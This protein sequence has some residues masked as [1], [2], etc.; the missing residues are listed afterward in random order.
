M[1]NDGYRSQFLKA[2]SQYF[3]SFLQ[4][5]CDPLPGATHDLLDEGCRKNFFPQGWLAMSPPDRRK[6]ARILLQHR[7]AACKFAQTFLAI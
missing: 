7:P 3:W 5:Q 1:L 2:F 6:K 4:W